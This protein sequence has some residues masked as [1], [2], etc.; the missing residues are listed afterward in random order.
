LSAISQV[1]T[2]KKFIGYDGTKYS[3]RGASE[4]AEAKCFIDVTAN[5]QR[6]D[7]AVARYALVLIGIS[8]E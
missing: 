5:I 7:I 1:C 4:N 2:G 8:E 6:V 3:I